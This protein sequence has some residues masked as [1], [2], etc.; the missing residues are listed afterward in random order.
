[1]KPAIL[2]TLLIIL[3]SACSPA[4]GGPAMLTAT[5]IIPTPTATLA[6]SATPLATETPAPPTITPLPTIPT[7][8]PTFD[9][10]TIVTATPAPKAECPKENPGLPAGFEVRTE[11]NYFLGGTQ[12]GILKFLNEGGTLDALKKRL[13]E[14]WGWNN[15]FVVQDITGDTLPDVLFVAYDSAGSFYAFKCNQGQYQMYSPGIDYSIGW[16]SEIIAVKDLNKD[17]LPEIV[18]E[19]R[20]CNGT[21]CADIYV[22]AWNGENLIDLSPKKEDDPSFGLKNSE[23]DALQKIKVENIDKDGLFEIS[24][25]GG[26][27]APSIV[28]YGY[29]FR[30]YTEILKWNG[31]SFAINSIEYAPPF[32]RFQAIQDADLDTKLGGYEKALSLYQDAIFSDKLEWWSP[33]RSKDT[34]KKLSGNNDY[35]EKVKPADGS[36]DP[37]E[38]PRLAAYAYYRMIILHTHLGQTDAAQIKYATL[39][40]KFPVGNPG[41]SYAEMAAAFQDAYQPSQ[42]MAAACAAAIQYADLHPEILTPLGSYDYHGW[43][44]HKY[45][46]ADVCPFR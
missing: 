45:V 12:N 6:P 14:A 10:R 21:D 4:I 42:D 8:T 40:D 29:P 46:P 18:L 43:Q 39:Q 27:P 38:Y 41:H 31:E 5:P 2:L 36:P 22:F 19:H 15:N 34:L 7:F 17:G 9:V 28:D 23:F 16:T 24:L 13:G 20:G 25:S 33:Q 11:D 30:S 35:P 1:M 26:I 44:S 3:L 32:F 37:T